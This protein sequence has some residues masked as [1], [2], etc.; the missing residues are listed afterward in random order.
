MEPWNP[1]F[2]KVRETW[3]TRF[4]GTSELSQINVK[5]DGQECPSHT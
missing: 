1:T 3:G 4:M 5:G 2:R